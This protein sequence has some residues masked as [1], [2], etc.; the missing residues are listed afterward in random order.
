MG[1]K[2]DLMKTYWEI[3]GRKDII[4]LHSD[5]SS[6]VKEQLKLQLQLMS[7]EASSQGQP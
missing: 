1:E 7:A 2:R 3:R 6:F 4:A 5:T